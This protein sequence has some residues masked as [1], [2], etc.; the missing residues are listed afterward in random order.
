MSQIAIVIWLGVRGLG[1]TIPKFKPE[2]IQ[3][4]QEMRAIFEK[5]GLKTSRNHSTQNEFI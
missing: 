4:V 5:T 3:D 2:S 1:R